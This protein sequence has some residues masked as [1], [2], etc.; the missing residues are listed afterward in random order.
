MP[1][2]DGER[3][4]IKPGTKVRLADID[5]GS[6]KGA[7]GDATKTAATLP[8]AEA[9]LFSL[10][11][12]LWAERKHAVLLVLQ[13]MDTSGKDGTVKHVLRG[14]NPQGVRVASF[15]APTEAEALHDY[16]WRVHART[17]EHG[18]LGVFN[19]SH[20]EDVLI[21]R[22]H[23]IAPKKVWGARFEQI[24]AFEEL[25]TA[26]GTTIVKV[27]L[28][29][30]KDEQARRLQA[31]LDNPDKNWKFNKGDLAE[32]ARWDDY[33]LAYEDLLSK[34]STKHAPWHLVPAD[35][36][37]YRNWAVSRLLIEAFD[38]IDPHYPP[39]VDDVSGIVI[40]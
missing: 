32:R 29:I 13:G 3:F 23:D 6:T 8:K 27:F 37:W 18:E 17:P 34:T 39:P 22:V 2:R 19:R 26:S 20:Y 36:K 1:N 40:A 25:L 9:K 4:R 11:D 30:S 5:S 35:H 21:V 15:K 24:N 33:Q 28:H 16:L 38:R 7:P 12:R 31:R 10:H 14:L